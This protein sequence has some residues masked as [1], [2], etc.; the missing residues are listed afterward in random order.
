MARKL[1]KQ[2]RIS[3]DAFAQR[4]GLNKSTVGSFERAARAPDAATVEAVAKALGVSIPAL[5][6][7]VPITVTTETR[8]L[9]EAMARLG[10]LNPHALNAFRLTM[11][12][13]IDEAL[14]ASSTPR[15]A[16][17]PRAGSAAG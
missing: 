12:R 4:A 11:L 2:R 15:S 14:K 6:A 16:A 9:L 3:V 17:R 5:Y 10:E 13:A 8:D 7:L 1:R